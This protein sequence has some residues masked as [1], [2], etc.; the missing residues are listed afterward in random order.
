LSTSLIVVL[1][2]SCGTP[3]RVPADAVPV[4]VRCE[5]CGS[6]LREDDTGRRVTVAVV[7]ALLLMMAGTAIVVLMR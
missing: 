2:S 1:C 3:H 7:L 6:S 5:V 4:A